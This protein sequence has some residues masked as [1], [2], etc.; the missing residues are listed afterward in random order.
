MLS[1]SVSF[2]FVPPA[3]SP[4]NV[5]LNTWFGKIIFALYCLAA[6]GM[7]SIIPLSMWLEREEKLEKLAH[8]AARWR[9]VF[10]RRFKRRG[11][12]LFL[13]DKGESLPISIPDWRKGQGK[14]GRTRSRRDLFK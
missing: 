1:P 10:D 8:I 11:S 14:V 12:V 7:I 5:D 13:Q 2:L 9:R 3:I 6:L 4:D